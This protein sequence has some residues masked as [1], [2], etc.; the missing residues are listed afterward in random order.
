MA[1]IE[2]LVR[3][4]VQYPAADRA[5]SAVARDPAIIVEREGEITRAGVA[6]ALGIS[7]FARLLEGVPTGAAYVDDRLAAGGQVCFDHGAIRTMG[8]AGHLAPAPN[9]DLPNGQEAFRRILEP[10][11]YAVADIYP[12]PRLQ[13]TGHVFCHR[14][15]P[16]AIPQ[17]FVSE[18]HVDC[19]DAGFAEVAARVFGTSCDPLG[20]AAHDLLE[21]LAAT[22]LAPLALAQ[23]GLPQILAAFERQHEI[24]ALA[25]YEALCAQSPEAAWIATEGNAFN[26]ATDRVYDVEA[27]AVAQRAAGRPIKDKVEVSASGRVRQTAYRADPVLRRFRTVDGEVERW[28]PGSFYE[29]ITR[30]ID[31]ATGQLDLAFDSGN[32]TGIFGMTKAA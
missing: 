23:A 26:H 11:G 3:A 10:L 17:Y 9:G 5:L 31:P 27:L 13:M 8:F 29:F 12:L 1:M 25:D 16:A 15:Y 6:M 4:N 19:F 18:L 22:G 7:L 30:A 2:Q 21:H 20:R 24:P 32:A 14:D 28:V